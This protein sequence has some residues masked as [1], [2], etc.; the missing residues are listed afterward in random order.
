[1]THLP[2][3]EN[4]KHR[5]GLYSALFYNPSFNFRQHQRSIENNH[6]SIYGD[7][8]S[9]NSSTRSSPSPSSPSA[10]A[11]IS[12]PGIFTKEEYMR[13]V[14]TRRQTFVH[15]NF[16]NVIS[17]LF[18]SLREDADRSK[19]CHREVVFEL[20]EHFDI[21][22]TEKTLCEYFSDCGYKAFPEA[23]KEHEHGRIVITI[24]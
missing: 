17:E 14:K 18:N 10:L 3:E 24:T 4:T 2:L 7:P 19:V 1:M 20:P 15:S 9:Q 5:M 22:K 13:I 16:G 8:M 6:T 11:E 21:D 23:R 12:M